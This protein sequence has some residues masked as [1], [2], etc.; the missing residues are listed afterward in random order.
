VSFGILKDVRKIT[1]DQITIIKFQD[2]N[3]KRP[4]HGK[5]DIIK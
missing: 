3:I 4:G 5:S 1:N 2:A